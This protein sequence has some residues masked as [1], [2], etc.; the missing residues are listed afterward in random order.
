MESLPPGLLAALVGLGGG[1]MLGLAARLGNFCTLGAIESAVY[2]GDQRRLRMWGI[3]LGTAILSVFGLAQAGMIDMSKSIYIATAWN[4]AASI[5]GGLIFGYGMAL[6]GN[7]GF[8]ALSRFGGGEI[9]AMVVVV[10]LGIFGFIAL[11]GPLA[12]LRVLLFPLSDTD[13]PQG[14]AHSLT[15]ATGLPLMLWAGIA[16]FGFLA[17][18]LSHAPLRQEPS[19][20]IWGVVAGLAIA[21]AFWGTTIVNEWSLEATQVAGHSYTVP[22]GRTLLYLMTTSAGGIDFPIGSVTGVVLGALIGSF[23]KGDFQWEGCEDPREL[24][25]L[26][27]G[28][29]LMGIGGAIA[30]GCSIGQGVSAFSMLAWSAP[31]TLA[32]IVVGALFG[33]RRLMQG[34]EPH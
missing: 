19:Y 5:V 33:L 4:P 29:A 32:S 11:N 16:G 9:R 21:S 10:V 1:I 17:A 7:C 2:G 3:V 14:I 27:I 12:D 30:M 34:F 23:I 28:A 15:Q 24:G 13:T 6:A 22:I 26:A 8:G 18:G 25:R 20:I 31:V